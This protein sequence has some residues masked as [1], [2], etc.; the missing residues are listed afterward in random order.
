[1]VTLSA[2]V[3]PPQPNG[4]GR[5]PRLGING[6]TAL[7]EII[8]PTPMFLTSNLAILG[9]R[10]EALVTKMLLKHSQAVAGVIVFNCVHRKSVPELMR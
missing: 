9:C 8:V 6:A 10:V 4:R 5:W 1:M 2:N 3:Q 7:P